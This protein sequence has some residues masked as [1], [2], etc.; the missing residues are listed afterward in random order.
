VLD[1]CLVRQIES[2][3]GNHK[4]PRRIDEHEPPILRRSHRPLPRNCGAAHND[5][6]LYLTRFSPQRLD[7][8]A[9]AA[10]CLTFTHFHGRFYAEHQLCERDGGR[11]VVGVP[12]DGCAFWEREPGA[13]DE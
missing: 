9:R 13:D 8:G 7:S 2:L 4:I 3:T 6:V 11:K 12:R 5:L 10:G 1:D